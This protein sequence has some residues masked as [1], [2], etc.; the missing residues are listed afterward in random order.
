MAA[1]K[2]TQE[3]LNLIYQMAS[4]IL[5]HSYIPFDDKN[6]STTEDLLFVYDENQKKIIESITEKCGR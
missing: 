4:K 3:E 2:F 6:Y 5:N 1:N